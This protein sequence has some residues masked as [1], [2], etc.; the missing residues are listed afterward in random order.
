MHLAFLILCPGFYL[1][2][3]AQTF[4]FPPILGGYVVVASAG[5]IVILLPTYIASLRAKRLAGLLDFLFWLMIAFA[6]IWVALSSLSVDAESVNNSYAGV[7]L[8]W[9]ALYFFAGALPFEK[10]SLKYLSFASFLMMSA[11]IFSNTRFGTFQLEVDEQE[12]SYQFFALF[13]II[14]LYVFLSMSSFKLLQSLSLLLGIVTLVF[15]GARSELFALLIGAIIL[16]NGKNFSIM[17]IAIQSSAVLIG[18]ALLPIV[19]SSAQNRLADFI[20]TQAEG[21]W[22]ERSYALQYALQVIA[23]NPFLGRYADYPPGLYAHNILS[24]YVDFGLLGFLIYITVL[25][26]AFVI[27]LKGIRRAGLKEGYYLALAMLIQIFVLLIVAKSGV[28]YLVPFALGFLSRLLKRRTVS[29]AS[30]PAGA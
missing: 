30:T 3:Y 4:G 28:Y 5:C 22:S 20:L 8:I 12:A 17:T 23:D 15:V 11:I 26:A 16:L 19:L 2:N 9:I 14:N 25:A 18:Y 29:S 6:I 21:S 10:T 24:I 1:Y 13:Y 27:V 7:L